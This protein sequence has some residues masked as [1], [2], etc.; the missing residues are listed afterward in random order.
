MFV[1]TVK[2]IKCCKCGEL[3]NDGRMTYAGECYCEECAPE[4]EPTHE[5]RVC[6]HCG[7]PMTEGMTDCARFYVHEGCF[8]DAMSER[9]AAWREVDDDGCDGYYEW[10][11]PRDDEWCGTGIFYTE[12]D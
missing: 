12:W 6:I 9:Y 4:N 7:K 2:L 10:Y 1:E 5:F 3:I 11:D 8:A